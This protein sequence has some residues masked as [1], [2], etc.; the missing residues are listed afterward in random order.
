MVLRCSLLGHDYG[1]AEVEREREER[2]S[3]VVVTVQEYEECTRCGERHVISEN[4]EVTSLSAGADGDSL[5][6]DPEPTADSDVPSQ[7][8]QP[9][10]ARADAAAADTDVAAGEDV[11]FID[12][13]ADASD[14][15]DD[16]AQPAAGAA[17]ADANAAAETDAPADAD[18]DSDQPT[19][20]NGEPITD[21]GEIIE[22]TLDEAADRDRGRGEWPDTDDVGPPV[23]ADDEPTAWPDDGIGDDHDPAEDDA[24]VLEHDSTTAG[25]TGSDAGTTV[26]AGSTGSD[27]GTTVD[28]GSTMSDIETTGSDI[29]GADVGSGAE[30]EID[31]EAATEADSEPDT[32][33]ERAGAAPTPAED[34]GPDE[35]GVPTEFYC[36]R[37]DF[38]AS[39]DRASLRAGDICPDCRKGYLGERP[40]R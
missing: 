5:P 28:A 16:A 27:A 8:D 6:D 4:T 33:I 17:E 21:D 39:D 15:S 38:V 34:T 36:P 31:A 13:D 18:V 3:E 20:E 11:E 25:A 7:S 1:D 29:A 19:D 35:D 23:G 24:V 26:D 10:Q 9:A 30:A 32:G 12:A 40:R 37:C 2:G 14:S 22:D